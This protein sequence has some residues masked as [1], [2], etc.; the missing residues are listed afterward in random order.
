MCF[1]IEVIL[2][3]VP[4]HSTDQFA[5]LVNATPGLLQLRPQDQ[6]LRRATAPRFSI[7]APGKDCAC[8]LL[9][10]SS[11]DRNNPHMPVLPDPTSPSEPIIDVDLDSEAAGALADT[12]DFLGNHAG[13]LGFEF[14]AAWSHQISPLSRE[15]PLKRQLWEVP[16]SLRV[17]NQLR[18]PLHEYL[19][20]NLP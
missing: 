9:A 8:S 18:I 13:R 1:V 11:R 7:S 2:P 5:A 16:Q 10:P 6:L 14:I 19:R 15:P 17:L 12:L 20:P 4:R 3:S